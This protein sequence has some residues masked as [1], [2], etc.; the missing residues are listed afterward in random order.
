[1]AEVVDDI[2]MPLATPG[3]PRIPSSGLSQ[4]KVEHLLQLSHQAEMPFDKLEALE[5][6]KADAQS[7]E[8]WGRIRQKPRIPDK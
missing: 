5:V 1:M 6:L 7:G 3:G 4:A 2:S 8:S